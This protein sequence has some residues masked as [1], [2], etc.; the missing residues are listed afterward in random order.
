MI[1]TDN[2]QRNTGIIGVLEKEIKKK[3]TGNYY[4]KL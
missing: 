3:P 4:L 1:D 2:R